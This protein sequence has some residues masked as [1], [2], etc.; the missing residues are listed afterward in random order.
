MTM[1][2]MRRVF[3]TT[4]GIVFLFGFGCGLLVAWWIL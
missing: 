3:V 2:Q 4:I 1:E